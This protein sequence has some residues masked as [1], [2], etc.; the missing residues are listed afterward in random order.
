M[1]W[2]ITLLSLLFLIE[3]KAQTQNLT[4]SGEV[5]DSAYQKPLYLA[6]VALRNAKDSLIAATVTDEQ[7]KFT[8]SELSKGDYKLKIS[9]VGFRPFQKSFT[10]DKESLI[11]DRVF[12]VE[13]PTDLESIS[14]EED[15]EAVVLKKDTVEF[16]ASA[17]KTTPEANLED[18]LKK[19]PGI[20][21]E[22]GKAKTQGKEITKIMVDGKPFFENDPKFTLK[23]LPADMVKKVQVI[24]EKSKEA[25]FTGHDDG[26]RTKVIN[27]VTKPEKRKGYFGRAGLTYSHPSRYNSNANLNFLRGKDRFSISGSYN[28]LGS[29][30]GGEYIVYPG[31]GIDVSNI[32]FSGGGGISESKSLST[33]YYSQLSEKLEVTLSYRYNDSN[34]RSIRDISR[35]FIQASDEGRIYNEKSENTSN[36]NTRSGSLRVSYRPSKKDQ[37]TFSQSLSQS[38]SNR[39]S[40]LEGRTLLNS[41]LLNSTDNFNFSESENSRWSNSLTY[42]HKFA[43]KG[44]T[45][46]FKSENTVSKGSGA[47]TVRSTN[48]F[49]SGDVENQIFD[50]ISDPDN[51]NRRH[52]AEVVYTEP[53]GEKNSLRFSYNGTLTIDDKQRLLLDFNEAD[54]AYTDLDPQR[55]SDYKLTN[56][57]HRLY[58]GIR[59][60]VK[61]VNVSLSSRFQHQTIENQQVYPNVIDTKNSFRGL[62]PNIRLTK[63][64][65]QGKQTS[66]TISRSM[67]APSANQ[68][69]DVIDNTNP[70]FIRQGNPGLNAS[71]SNTI[72][73][74]Y[75][76]YNEKSKSFIQASANATFTDNSIVNS[77]I[78]GN[79]DNSPEGI[80]LPIGARLTR[81]VNIGGRRSMRASIN[82]SKPLKEKKLNLGLGGSVSYSRNPQFLNEISQVAESYNY[83]LSLRLSSNFNEK[84]DM[85]VSSSPS[86]SVVNNSNREQSDRK[87]FSLSSAFRVTWVFLDGFSVSSTLSNRLQGQVQGIPANNQWLWN[88]SLSKK[89]FKKKL[90]FRISATD[91]LRQ[92][93]VINRNVTSEYI[94][95]SETNVLRQIFRFSLAYKFTKM[96]GGK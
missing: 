20:E 79:G 14:V 13:D 88:M 38:Q 66:L 54:N 86:Y 87:F 36:S 73:F 12:M 96:G 64:S 43:K 26:Q 11:V 46:S 48:I 84:L 7:G 27:V 42:R 16:N 22:D 24:D 17:F 75:I 76:N 6:N 65:E 53:I 18:L 92:N 62:L 51:S 78:V 4:V 63:S 30:G 91:I 57:N 74:S 89:F 58:A 9:F 44:R 59:F 1:K 5:Y 95:N 85:S 19:M 68:L 60:K 2:F 25:Q 8:L 94:Q 34:T 72:S 55:S 28:N 10:L 81:P 31:G 29:G 61:A 80:V 3:L 15:A 41:E 21:V 77:T 71:F 93:A 40:Q 45:I 23:N 67:R 33:Y 90:D 82:M 69:Q 50:Q 35:Q 52:L 47:D 56:T 70:L 83:G 32:Q 39:F 37:I 49:T